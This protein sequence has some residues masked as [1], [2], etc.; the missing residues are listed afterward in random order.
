MTEKAARQQA[1]RFGHMGETVSA[2]M[3]RS[4]G[5]RVVMRRFKTPVGEIDLIC[6]RGNLLVFVE[7]KARRR[8]HVNDQLLSGAQRRRISRAA[9]VFLQRYP[10]F[11]NHDI[12]FDMVVIC[13]WT[14]PR[15][16]EGAWCTES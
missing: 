8:Q 13:P 3:L 2:W 10:A 7:V 6:R 1:W 16:L 15:H 4:K 5:Y 14:Y 11:A 12:R 9:L